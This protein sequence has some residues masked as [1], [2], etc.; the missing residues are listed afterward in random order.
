[1]IF[2]LE[3]DSV[4]FPPTC[5]AEKDGLLALG[6]DL[7]PERLLAA[8]AQ[9]IFPWFGPESPPLWYAPP[10]RCVLRP[11]AVKQSKSMRQLANSGRFRTTWDQAFDAVITHC[12]SIRREGQEGTW[13]TEEMQNAYSRLHQMGHAHSLEVWDE[14]GLAGGL[15]GLA[16]GEVFCGESMFSL[17][18]NAS[19]TA[20]IAL[21][22][23]GG[24]LLIDC[25]V[26]NPH[27]LSMGA[28]IW[29]REAFE[30]WLP[31]RCGT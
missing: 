22:R 23:E 19:K 27:L 14:Q 2:E 10:E 21:C 31:A 7:S 26:P 11:D 20:L 30:Q 28:E 12:A 6:G 5:L 25:Q 16:M 13:I 17:R 1:M 3:A 9:G 24:Y 29:P 18:A 4:A 8:Y 15:Y